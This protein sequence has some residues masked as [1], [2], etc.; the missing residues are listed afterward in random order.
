MRGLGEGGATGHRRESVVRP[1]QVDPG[2]V[3]VAVLQ[4][5]GGGR[6]LS[7]GGWEGG[8]LSELSGARAGSGQRPAGSA[9]RA[10]GRQWQAGS[11]QPA[12]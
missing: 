11:R 9:S 6:V 3:C 12:P 5:G 8:A 10:A 4:V 7:E 1:G 2:V